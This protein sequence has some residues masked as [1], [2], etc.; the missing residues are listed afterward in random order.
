[1]TKDWLFWVAVGISLLTAISV[2][3]SGGYGDGEGAAVALDVLF[4]VAVNL[5]FIIFPIWA[6][7]SAVRRS[8]A[9]RRRRDATA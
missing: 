7:R 3:Q 6:V 9:R 1:M 2:T 8:R 4:G 5:L